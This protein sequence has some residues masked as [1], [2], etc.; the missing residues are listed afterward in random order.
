MNQ[1]ALLSIVEFL[2]AIVLVVGAVY[3]SHRLFL[4]LL[5]F[6]RDAHLARDNRAVGLVLSTLLV[7]HGFVLLRAFSPVRF[8][9]RAHLLGPGGAELSLPTLIGIA[10]LH[11]GFSFVVALFAMW[12][13]VH[14]F[15]WLT[16]DLDHIQAI[17]DGNISVA[18]VL[19]GVIIVVALFLAQGIGTLSTALLPQPGFGQIEQLP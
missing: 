9:F 6:E 16:G 8:L 17:R 11:L 3:S 14:L 1:D 5:P 13:A 18:L 12:L 2:G 15:D 4:L 19:A 7:A 10:A